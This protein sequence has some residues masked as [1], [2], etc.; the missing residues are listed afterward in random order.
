MYEAFFASYCHTTGT[1]LYFSF[2]ICCETVFRLAVLAVL[3]VRS[4]CEKPIRPCLVSFGVCTA[5][6]QGL[7]AP[8]KI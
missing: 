4:A 6:L 3:F 2:K 5:D 7:H 8:G 1:I